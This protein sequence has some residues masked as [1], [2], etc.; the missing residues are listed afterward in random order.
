MTI[1]RNDDSDEQNLANPRNTQ[2]PDLQTN[3]QKNAT[4][5]QCYSYKIHIKKV[6][7]ILYILNIEVFLG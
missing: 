6:K 5:L 7:N 3:K 2:S 4:V 1:L